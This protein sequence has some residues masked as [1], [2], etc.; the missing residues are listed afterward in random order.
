MACK[1]EGRS[2]KISRWYG[3]GGDEKCKSDKRRKGK[4]QF[5]YTSLHTTFERI[6]FSFAAPANG[7]QNKQL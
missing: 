3:R 6:R 1:K 2:A 4:V 7:K 5:I